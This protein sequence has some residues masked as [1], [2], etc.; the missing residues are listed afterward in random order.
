[1]PSQFRW[2][3]DCMRSHRGKTTLASVPASLVLLLILVVVV[4]VFVL[5]LI[6]ILLGLL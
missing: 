1:M 2:H 5:L 3:G 6:L 4:L